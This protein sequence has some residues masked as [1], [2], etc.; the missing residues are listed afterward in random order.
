MEVLGK[1]RDFNIVVFHGKKK[2]GK[3]FHRLFCLLG[4]PVSLLP[5]TESGQE[6]VAQLLVSACQACS[7]G[8]FLCSIIACT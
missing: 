7:K 8:R 6:S 2:L 1:V 5:E 4:F 3:K